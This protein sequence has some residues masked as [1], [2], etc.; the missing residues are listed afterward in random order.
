MVVEGN[1]HGMQETKQWKEEINVLLAKGEGHHGN[2]EIIEAS[3]RRPFVTINHL[4]RHDPKGFEFC[5][6]L[7]ACRFGTLRDVYDLR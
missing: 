4:T 3:K 6:P 7:P 1:F 5:D 2:S